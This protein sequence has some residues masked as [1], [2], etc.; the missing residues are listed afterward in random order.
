MMTHVHDE[1]SQP[2]FATTPHGNTPID[3]SLRLPSIREAPSNRNNSLRVKLPSLRGAPS[4]N[5][6][7]NENDTIESGLFESFLF[8]VYRAYRKM[9]HTKFQVWLN[10]A[11]IYFCSGVGLLILFYPMNSPTRAYI[12]SVLILSLCMAISKHQS[13]L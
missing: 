4:I 6:S 5:F 13:L 9:Y 1:R 8:Y 3:N 7:L 2:N 12:C 11:N 10:L